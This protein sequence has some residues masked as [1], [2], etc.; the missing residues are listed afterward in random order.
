[1]LSNTH[2][3][4]WVILVLLGWLRAITIIPWWDWYWNGMVWKKSLSE[5]MNMALRFCANWK[6]SESDNP[7]LSVPQTS[8]TSCL[9]SRNSEEDAL[10]IFSST[11]NFMKLLS[12]KELSQ[13]WIAGFQTGGLPLYFHE[14]Y[15]DSLSATF[16]LNRLRPGHLEYCSPKHAYLWLQVYHDILLSL[17]KFYFPWFNPF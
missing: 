14:R 5:V 2:L 7:S 13:N 3:S 12:H 16:Q 17:L 8:I 10:G 1:M 15:S 6:I 9:D 11:R 4:F